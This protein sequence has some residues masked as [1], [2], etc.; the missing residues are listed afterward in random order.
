MA[1]YINSNVTDV[2]IPE[3]C[4]K[5]YKPPHLTTIKAMST[6]N[7]R[8]FYWAGL[9]ASALCFVA[10]GILAAYLDNVEDQ[11]STIIYVGIGAYIA[12]KVSRMKL[13][14]KLNDGFLAYA[15]QKYG[16]KPDGIGYTVAGPVITE[17]VSGLREFSAHCRLPD[18]TR[19]QVSEVTVTRPLSRL[20]SPE[21]YNSYGLKYFTLI[22]DTGVRTPHIFIDGRSQNRFRRN[23]TDLWSLT[24]RLDKDEKLQDME[25]DFYKYFDVYSADRK[26]LSSFTIMTPDTMLALRDQ[27]SAFDYE[28]HDGILYV[29]H[30]ANF[31]DE[32]EYEKCFTALTACLK[33]LVP[34]IA[35]HHYDDA[36]DKLRL[37]SA[38]LS[39][40]AL[41]YS[42]RLIIAALGKFLLFV[43][44]TVILGQVLGNLIS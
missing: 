39:F 36:G 20:L 28:L 41:V 43:A 27:G 25:G 32:A 24:K 22:V 14:T 34:Q 16:I 33:E 29:I 18:G 8:R 37:G 19:V 26:Y 9:A 2:S 12:A 5:L 1:N 30:E 31:R 15:Y 23:S 11:A 3:N 40:W 10:A 6:K 7:Y 42:S 4:R 17:G 44:A 21:S 35:K 13:K 38:K